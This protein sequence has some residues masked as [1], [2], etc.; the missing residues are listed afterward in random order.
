MLNKLQVLLDL[1]PMA[2]V[3]GSVYV[4]GY[5]GRLLCIKGWR[6]TGELVSYLPILLLVGA[7]VVLIVGIR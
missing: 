3:M 1:L 7:A 2:I 4:C 6:K 5:F